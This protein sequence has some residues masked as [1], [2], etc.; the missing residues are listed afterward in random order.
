MHVL[1]IHQVFVSPNQGGG[2]RHYELAQSLLKEGHRFTV[3]ASNIGYVTQRPI[4]DGRGLVREQ[5]VGGIRVLR[6]YTYPSLQ[7]S[8]SWRVIAFLS[9]MC[10]SFWASLRA[11]P[12]DVVMSTSPPIFQAVSGWL[13][14]V[15]CRRPF[16]LE[17]RDLWPEFAIDIG[18][19]KNPM[20]IV[21]SRWLERF[22]YARATHILVN[23]PAYRDYL[24]DKGVPSAKLSFIPNGVDPDMFDPTAN[25]ERIRQQWGLDAKFVVTYAGAMGLANDIPTIL[26]AAD[27]LRDQAHIRFLLVGGG[28]KRPDLESLAR[29]LQLQNVIFAGGYPKS[30]MREVLAASDA[31]IATLK[32]IPAFRTTYP[33]KVFD[34]MAA[35]RPTILAIDGVIRQ[36]VEAAG[37]GVFVPPGDDAALADA[38]YSMSQDRQRA[39]AMGRAARAY[40][41]EHFNRHQHA[42]QF[43][44]LVQYL[45]RG[46]RTWED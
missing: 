10:T 26:R 19:L 24:L 20:L 32:D 37:G 45:A 36:V 33:N 29:Q 1:L 31:C 6:A 25:G 46:D 34:Y 14:A 11:G 39:A 42:A 12:V 28:M 3:V 23:S 30:E 17:I 16:L 27:R 8:F 4:V 7:R 40:V 22:L 35:G 2:T 38:V 41:V 43:L 5:R 9:F 15:I 21:L 44:E 18:V 13:M